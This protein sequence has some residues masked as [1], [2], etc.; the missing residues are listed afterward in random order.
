M[1]MI[2]EQVREI[3]IYEKEY[4]S[5]NTLGRMIQGTEDILKNAAETIEELSAKLSSGNLERSEQH[6][7]ISDDCIGKQALIKAIYDSGLLDTISQ[8]EA[9]LLGET[10]DSISLV[11]ALPVVR[12]KNCRQWGTGFPAETDCVKCCRYAGYMVGENGYCVYGERK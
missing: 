2:S 5:G 4:R 3:R 7:N 10:I 6:Y 9:T 12:C 11:G 1:S 8:P